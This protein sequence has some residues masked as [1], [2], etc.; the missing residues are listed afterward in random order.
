MKSLKRLSSVGTVV[1]VS[2]L[3]LTGCGAKND[4]AYIPCTPVTAAPTATATP[5]SSDAVPSADGIVAPT[6]APAA[7]STSSARPCPIVSTPKPTGTATV[8]PTGTATP[9]KTA[10][11]APT[12][13]TPATIA[14][15]SNYHPGTTK[16]V[17]PMTTA[18]N[19]GST[20]SKP[21][22]TTG[23]KSASD[24]GSTVPSKSSSGSGGGTKATTKP[25]KDSDP[26]PSTTPKPDATHF[27]SLFSES[28]S[29]DATSDSW[30]QADQSKSSYTG[31]TGVNW[32][33]APSTV[34]DS[35]GNP[36]SQ[37]IVSVHDGVLDINPQT[38]NNVS[39]G[40]LI[41]PT[42]SKASPYQKYGKFSFT[43]KTSSPTNPYRLTAALYPE[44]G[45][46]LTDGEIV[47][48]D[49]L[50]NQSNGVNGYYLFGGKDCPDI[51]C[52]IQS[53]P[54]AGGF[55]SQESHTY[56]VEWTP[57]SIKYSI[58]NAV[59]F[60][61]DSHIPTQPMRFQIAVNSTAVN[62]VTRDTND[63]H[64]FISD[65]KVWKYTK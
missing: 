42:A 29:K 6:T 53:T 7:A 34:K 27:V 52:V 41:T 46:P 47:F 19:T 54:V 11:P 13:G 40:A 55:N 43:M 25:T 24:A 9:T 2:I 60:T 22:T 18:P 65:V 61:L 8:K 50:L 57:T 1:A 64:V 20:A 23:G 26:S 15:P 49:G 44:S 16:A 14:G 17:T 33:S 21:V 36:Y 62:D 38:I 51:G 4:D 32:Y 63:T 35:F 30:F 28:F 10:T 39:S 59:V 3:L 48:P 12:V 31:S 56:T 58:N 37:S 5:D 45:D